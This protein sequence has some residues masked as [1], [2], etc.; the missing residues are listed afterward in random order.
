M[1]E[2]SPYKPASYKDIADILSS[3]IERGL[4]E[5]RFPIG[6][7][8]KNILMDLAENGYVIA[9]KSVIAGTGREKFIDGILDDLTPVY[10]GRML[11]DGDLKVIVGRVLN[12]LPVA[13]EFQLNEAP[14]PPP[15]PTDYRSDL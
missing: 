7:A 15:P 8:L 13:A 1:A 9:R 3:A 11:T 2:S 12:A 14:T 10:T 5:S 6:H 4:G